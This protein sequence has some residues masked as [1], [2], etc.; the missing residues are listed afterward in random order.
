MSDFTPTFHSVVEPIVDPVVKEEILEEEGV[1][2]RW[3]VLLFFMMGAGAAILLSKWT[4]EAAC[5][6]TTLSK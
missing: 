3:P 6:R 2:I 4:C 1:E 5:A